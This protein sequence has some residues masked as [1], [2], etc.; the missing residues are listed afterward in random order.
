MLNGDGEGW[1]LSDDDGL[2]ILIHGL[3]DLFMTIYGE[4]R[5]DFDVLMV[6][7]PYELLVVI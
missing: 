1:M 3:S 6:C 2:C 7:V 4:H 5:D